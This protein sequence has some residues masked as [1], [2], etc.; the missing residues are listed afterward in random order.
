MT[1][2]SKPSQLHIDTKVGLTDRFKIAFYLNNVNYGGTIFCD[3]IKANRNNTK[4]VVISNNLGSGILFDLLLPHKGQ[5]FVFANK[6]MIGAR[7][8]VNYV[9]LNE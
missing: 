9:D 2:N 5:E 6:I 8:I 1:N 3:S 7:P 4:E